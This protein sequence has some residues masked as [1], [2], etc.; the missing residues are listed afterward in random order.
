[1]ALGLETKNYVPVLVALQLWW[2]CNYSEY[3]NNNSKGYAESPEYSPV[4]GLIIFGKK[5]VVCRYKFGS[6]VRKKKLYT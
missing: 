4:L 3:G 2:R 1:M 5:S 6:L